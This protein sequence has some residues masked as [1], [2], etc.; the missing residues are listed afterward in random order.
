MRRPRVYGVTLLIF[1]RMLTL[2]FSYIEVLSFWIFVGFTGNCLLTYV[3]QYKCEP[4]NVSSLLITE[5]R[6]GL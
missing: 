4:Y 5:C 6:Y 1:L 3:T 2:G